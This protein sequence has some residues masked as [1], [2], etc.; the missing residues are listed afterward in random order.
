MAS[1]RVRQRN[2]ALSLDGA[3]D[4]DVP[5]IPYVTIRLQSSRLDH[6]LDS[7]PKTTLKMAHNLPAGEVKLYVWPGQWDL[8][9]YDSYS[10]SAIMYLQLAIPGKFHV[11]ECTDPDLSPSGR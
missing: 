5:N 7:K 8:P 3:A 2:L 10:L 11:V 9:S 4:A 1:H 6:D